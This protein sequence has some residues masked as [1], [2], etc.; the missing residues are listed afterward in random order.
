MIGTGRVSVMV[1]ARPE[2]IDS[3]PSVT[4][5]DG[6]FTLVTSTPDMLPISAPMTR[7]MTGAR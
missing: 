1:K 7:M 6:I 3:M 5:K 2:K 4:R